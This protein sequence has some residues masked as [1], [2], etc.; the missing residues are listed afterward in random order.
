[1]ISKAFAFEIFAFT[2]TGVK[3]RMDR[4]AHKERKRFG[5]ISKQ[6]SPFLGNCF[7]QIMDLFPGF[8]H[9]WKIEG[10]L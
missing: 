5:L 2:E 3:Q 8:S 7:L 4:I 10:R 6:R 1:M 9:Y